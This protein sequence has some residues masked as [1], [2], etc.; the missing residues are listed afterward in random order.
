[1][2]GQVEITVDGDRCAGSLACV[3]RAP[4]VFLLDDHEGQ[5][6]PVAPQPI[7]SLPALEA[8]AAACPTG[9]IGLRRVD[10]AGAGPAASGP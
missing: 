1:M 8:I 7:E 9:A 4:A 2:S 3:R 6:V 5:A 10:G